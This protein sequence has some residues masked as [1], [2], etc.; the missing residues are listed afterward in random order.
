M[1]DTTGLINGV[2]RN[3]GTPLNS[4]I[5]YSQSDVIAFLNEELRWLIQTELSLMRQ[6]YFS[7]TVTVPLVASQSK[8]IVPQLATG[9]MLEEVYYKGT[10]NVNRRIPRRTNKHELNNS[11]GTA[12]YP[13]MF[14]FEGVYLHLYPEMA[15]TVEGS[16]E[17]TYTR[18]QNLLTDVGSCSTITN[19]ATGLTDYTLTVNAIPLNYANGVDIIS[20][21]SPYEMKAKN[22]TATA[23]AL[24][25]TVAIADCPVVP[26]VG[27][28]IAETGYT[29]VPLI[30]SEFHPILVQAASIRW[31][32]G[33]GD[34]QNAKIAQERLA[35]MIEQMKRATKDRSLNAPKK[36]VPR[37]Y[38]LNSMRYRIY[39]R[40]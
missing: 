2:I 33:S 17:L 5:K 16:L 26:V 38:V 18:I 21:K 32:E 34:I 27:D 31:L 25:I 19:V 15:T 35:L 30:P 14:Y 28:Y 6:E 3:V 22:A 12:S 10:D 8:Y 4:P 11:T 23:G 20:N 1:Y 24:T 37:N 39:G 9:W 40:Y 13:Q 7:E 36:L 29:P